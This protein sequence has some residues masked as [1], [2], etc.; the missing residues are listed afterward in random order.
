M[1]PEQIQTKQW[2]WYTVLI[3]LIIYVG[4]SAWGFWL[5]FEK[6][7]TDEKF[8]CL[9]NN[10][11]TVSPE[12][13]QGSNMTNT[14]LLVAS[15]SAT[16]NVVRNSTNALPFTSVLFSPPFVSWKNGI[17]YTLT[18]AGIGD[19]YEPSSDQSTTTLV[20]A[21]LLSFTIQ[22][23]P[24]EKANQYC[25]NI[26]LKRI[27]DENGSFVLPD[28]KIFYSRE[29]L[30]GEAL[31][32]KPCYSPDATYED[33]ILLFSVSPSDNQ[34][35]FVDE[36]TL[37]SFSITIN[38]KG[39][40]S[41]SEECQNEDCVAVSEGASMN[42]SSETKYDVSNLTEV[43]DVI[44]WTQAV[45]L[46][47]ACQVKTVTKGNTVGEIKLV[48]DRAVKVNNTPSFSMIVDI[49]RMPSTTCGFLIDVEM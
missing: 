3:A 28:E 4:V 26:G 30:N 35:I 24:F 37:T 31:I 39:N 1:D 43:L 16:I 10:A 17:E 40:I 9:L 15:A 38:Q 25:P 22:I 6:G 13:E 7:T 36:K 21:L 32:A 33:Q 34:I 5:G 41:I 42:P 49:V 19:V 11:L 18:G 47:E 45:G 23:P 2:T 48:S 27:I 29:L 20:H 12:Y 8:Q 44:S 14:D 46:I